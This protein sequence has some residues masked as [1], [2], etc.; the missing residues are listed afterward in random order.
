MS[1]EE[2]IHQLRF[3]RKRKTNMAGEK[4]VTSKQMQEVKKQQRMPVFA[5][6]DV[7]YTPRR[8]GEESFF[9]Q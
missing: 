1:D 6:I 3:R 2:S 5:R 7:K 8:I 4:P 9:S